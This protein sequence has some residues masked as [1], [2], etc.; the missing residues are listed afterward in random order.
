MSILSVEI[1]NPKARKLLQDL[2]DLKL[3]SIKES[4]S[5]I[6]VLDRIR[7]KKSPLSLEEITREVEIVREK[8]H[9]T[10]A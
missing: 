2:E 10:K 7:S 3:I 9:G 8:R 6:E 4:N 1:L 5:L